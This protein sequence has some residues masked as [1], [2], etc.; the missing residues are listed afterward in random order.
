MADAIGA[1]A[2][3]V[4]QQYGGGF[5]VRSGTVAVGVAPVVIVPNDPDRVAV[6]VINIG[7]TQVTLAFRGDLTAGQGIVLL[8]NGSAYSVNV[9]D[10]AILPAWEHNGISNL[11]GG[12]I[13]VVEI[14]RETST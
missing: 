10:D 1:A 5:V 6:I 9:R 3:F 13:F 12:S 4:A 7:T 2:Q 11:A 8:D 14:I